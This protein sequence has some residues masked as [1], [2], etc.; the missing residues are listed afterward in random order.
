[1]KFVPTVPTTR[2]KPTVVESNTAEGKQQVDPKSKRPFAPNHE[3]SKRRED[4]Q[5][6]VSGT[7]AHGFSTFGAQKR[8]TSTTGTITGL[9][10]VKSSSTQ[11]DTEMHAAPEHAC[12]LDDVFDSLDPY[13]PVSSSLSCANGKD[14]LTVDLENGG[15][16]VIEV[17]GLYDMVANQ[18]RPQQHVSA[19]GV[20]NTVTSGTHGEEIIVDSVDAGRGK[21]K[22]NQ[23]SN[24]WPCLNGQ[25]GMLHKHASGKYTLQIG[26]H[27]F[28]VSPG[29]HDSTAFVWSIDKE[30]NTSVDMGPVDNHLITKLKIV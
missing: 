29:L 26:E 10:R 13:S 19:G 12:N 16:S 18:A 14:R 7:F 20:A 30:E 28:E 21:D 3:N 1:M 5:G 8:S 6:P 4:Q 24:T 15:L 17:P 27:V 11:D 9:S 2:R 23:S 22:D 25:I